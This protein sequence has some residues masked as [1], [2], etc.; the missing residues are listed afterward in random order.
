M[1]SMIDAINK[2]VSVR[3]YADRPIENDK[4][5]EIINLL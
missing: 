1:E 3:S 2:R 5:Q 4:K